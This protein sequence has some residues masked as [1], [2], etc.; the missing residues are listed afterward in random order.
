MFKKTG[1]VSL[2]ELWRTTYA[3]ECARHELPKQS[4]F[5]DQTLFWE[6]RQRVRNRVNCDHAALLWGFLEKVSRA[7]V[8]C[9]NGDLVDASPEL[10]DYIDELSWQ[11][12]FVDLTVGTVGSAGRNRSEEPE[13]DR[14]ISEF[15]LEALHVQRMHNMFGPFL[16]CPILIGS[17]EF[18]VFCNEAW[19]VTPTAKPYINN[20]E[21]IT[22]IVA[23]KR[24]DPTR[25]R[26]WLRKTFCAELKGDLF[27]TIF[28]DAAKIEPLLSK[29]GMVAGRGRRP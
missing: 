12:T 23:A 10:F 14:V 28:R 2:R 22:L 3:F 21:Y 11:G 29:R 7:V 20:D 5:A 17:E 16:H 27:R 6:A 15:D 8:L 26:E 18:A 19:Q 4:N 24:E 25:S 9:G 1:F 13:D